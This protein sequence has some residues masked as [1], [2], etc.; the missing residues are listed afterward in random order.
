[1]FVYLVLYL[2]NLNVSRVS[3]ND[4]RTSDRARAIAMVTSLRKVKRHFSTFSRCFHMFMS[5]IVYRTTP[6]PT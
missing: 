1:M 3:R 4:V 2:H 6:R 5:K